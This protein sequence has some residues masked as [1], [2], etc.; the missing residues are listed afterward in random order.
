M[1]IVAGQSTASFPI[2]PLNDLVVDGTQTVTITASATGYVDGDDTVDVIDNPFPWQNPE[3]RYDVN[4]D[5]FITPTDVLVVINGINQLGPQRLPDPT[6]EFGPPPFYDVNGDGFLSP[7]DAGAIVN[8]LNGGGGGEVGE[9]ELV[10]ELFA[11]MTG[12]EGAL[13]ARPTAL[14]PGLQTRED[15]FAGRYG[16]IFGRAM[17]QRAG[18]RDEFGSSVTA[19]AIRQRQLFGSA[20]ATFVD[21]SLTRRPRP[22]ATRPAERPALHNDKLEALLSAIVADIATIRRSGRDPA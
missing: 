17:S 20:I 1:V 11:R 3:N 8:F 4:G 18:L 2:V 9:G 21:A 10:S 19:A 7:A 22:H 13:L 6:P 5:G 15:L 14:A 16:S 12:A